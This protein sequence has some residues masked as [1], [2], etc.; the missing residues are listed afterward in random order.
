MT[1]KTKKWGVVLVV[2]ALAAFL[3]YHYS[4]S[5]KPAAARAVAAVGSIVP[6]GPF[7][8]GHSEDMLAKAR[9][10]YAK[11]N[12]DASIESYKA[13]VKKNPANPDAIG[14]LGNVYYTTGK[15]QEAAQAYHDAASLLIDQK[16]EMR[17]VELMPVIDQINPELV[18]DLN[19]KMAKANQPPQAPQEQPQS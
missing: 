13:Y 1:S 7:G 5:V 6:S 18:N 8:K 19:E 16:Q 10:D 4:D 15:M 3:V 12:I 11:G 9:E 14:E 2:L 17:A